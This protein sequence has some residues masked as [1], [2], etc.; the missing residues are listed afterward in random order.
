MNFVDRFAY[1]L[2]HSRV[3]SQMGS[4]PRGK[5]DKVYSFVLRKYVTAEEARKAKED[6]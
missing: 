1:T 6:K 4:T 3:T 5:V 2:P